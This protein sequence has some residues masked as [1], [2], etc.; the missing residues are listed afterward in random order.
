MILV[1]C[2]NGR[3]GTAI[4]K[5]L[6]KDEDCPPLRIAARD[7]TKIDKSLAARCALL[8]VDYDDPP[9]MKA[10]FN[11]VTTLMFISSTAANP[12]RIRQHQ[13][14]IDAARAAGVKRIVYTSFTEPTPSSLFTMVQAHVETE[15]MLGDS[16]ISHAIL[17]NNQYA[18]NIDG[19]VAQAIETGTLA[20]QIGRAH[21]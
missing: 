10:A 17:R 15:R 13:A 20:M 19:F 3:L 16:G 2:A 14:V 18:A 5:A 12:E 11:R 6:L 8:K 7:I 21:V 9:S 4:I 1:T